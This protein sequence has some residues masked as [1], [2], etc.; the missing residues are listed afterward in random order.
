MSEIE[1]TE[2]EFKSL[3]QSKQ[4]WIILKTFEAQTRE[5]DSR[6]CSVEDEINT[7]NARKWF[8]AGASAVGGFIGGA[9]AVIGKTIFFKG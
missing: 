2:D 8:H 4:N 7:I 5:C 6:F 3:P 1:V 9:I